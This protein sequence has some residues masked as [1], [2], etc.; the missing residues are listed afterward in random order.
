MVDAVTNLVT[1]LT[2]EIVTILVGVAI[3][4]VSKKAHDVLDRIKKKDELG[5]IDSITNQT[6]DLVEAELKGAKGEEKLQYAIDKAIEILA[7]KKI[8]V[9]ETEIRAGI[10]NGVKK[11]NQVK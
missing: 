5:I 11:L 6:V 3:T 7:T 10:E 8:T 2:A 1:N 9:S 4:F